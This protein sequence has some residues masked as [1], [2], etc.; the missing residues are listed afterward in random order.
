MNRLPPNDIEQFI[1]KHYHQIKLLHLSI[2]YTEINYGVD[3]LERLILPYLPQLKTFQLQ[4]AS[5][6]FCNYTNEIYQCLLKHCGFQGWNIRQRFFTHEPMSEEYL[7]KI[8][9][10]F[11]PHM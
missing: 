3:I 10:S 5:K 9:C 2:N 4:D 8:F 11:K 1:K 6:I 7:H